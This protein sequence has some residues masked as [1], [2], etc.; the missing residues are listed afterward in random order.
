MFKRTRICTSSQDTELTKAL[1]GK[2]GYSIMLGI[3][4]FLICFL[5]LY[6]SYYVCTCIGNVLGGHT[7]SVVGRMKRGKYKTT[8][9]CC[10]QFKQ[11]ERERQ[12]ERGKRERKREKNK[13]IDGVIY[14]WKVGFQVIFLF[15]AL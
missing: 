5:K 4:V 6:V 9:A 11:G 1:S 7:L 10:S 14:P 2:S 3:I 15:A 12:E 13:R 8:S